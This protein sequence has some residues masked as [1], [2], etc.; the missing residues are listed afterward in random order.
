M[1]GCRS[2]ARPRRPVR[3][4]R[5]RARGDGRDAPP[6]RRLRALRGRGALAGGPAR[7]ARPG[8]RWTRRPRRPSPGLEDEVLDRFVRERAAAAPRRRR[9]PRVAIPAIA[10]AARSRP[11]WSR[12][13]RAGQTPPTRART[14]G[15]C[16][17]ATAPP[18]ARGR[19]GGRGHAREAARRPPAGADGHRLRALVRAHRRQL[20]E[21]AAAS[22]RARTAP[23]RRSSPRRSWPG[24]YH[25]VV[26]T[27]RSSGGVRGAE[28]MRGKLD[29]LNP[30]VGGR[31]HPSM[32]ALTLIALLCALA[33][34]VAG[35]GG[36]DDELG[37]RRR[38]RREHAGASTPG[39]RRRRER[40]RRA[41][42][43]KIAADPSG[44][45]KFDKS[46][47]TAKAGKVTIVM[48]N[49]SDVPA[50]GRDRGRRRRGRGRDGR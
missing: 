32:R 12:C 17:P 45:L 4:R 22:T 1:S 10:V 13:S 33:I 25:V 20:D 14:C 42:T 23:R 43:L 11:S 40:R 7:A 47:L 27:R 39:G 37:R 8:W 9:W 28:V 29:L 24:E 26:I 5:A 19:R 35:C 49:P 31:V 46:S 36:D 48:D 34:P 3:P 41:E 2:H 16:R 6:P 21:A 15:A 18:A 38:W 50:R 44:A 30:A